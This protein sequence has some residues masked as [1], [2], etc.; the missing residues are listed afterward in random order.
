MK[1]VFLL[2]TLVLL[3]SCSDD[4]TSGSSV[5][6]AKFIDSAVEGLEYSSGDLSGTTASG[7]IFTCNSGDI[8]T[9]KINSQTLG[10]ASC[11][12]VV[13]PY[14]IQS[15]DGL[16][17]NA[18][19]NMVFLLQNLDVDGDPT[20]GI[21]IEAAKKAVITGAISLDND[22]D[23][24][25]FAGNAASAGTNQNKITKTAALDHLKAFGLNVGTYS[26]T[27]ELTN[28]P[29][30]NCSE[31]PLSLDFKGDSFS[32]NVD[33]T[34]Y[35]EN[36]TRGKAVFTTSGTTL[37][38]GGAAVTTVSPDDAT[39]AVLGGGIPA[40]Y[41]DPE[42]TSSSVCIGTATYKQHAVRLTNVSISSGTITGEFAY[43]AQCEDNSV[44]SDY[45]ECNGDFT[46]T[47]K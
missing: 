30:D 24:D 1:K 4:S 38:Y 7:G 5:I 45:D 47:K 43:I 31:L 20:N 19:N 27:Y 40:Y 41:K 11:G 8:V 14:S 9:F 12:S 42:E 36:N 35:S 44:I 16:D 46:F 23:I 13:T 26:G 28:N 21:S 33:G 3:G 15:K 32:V 37:S 34:T 18:L 39:A 6:S 29:Q 2:L 17:D 10:T 25:T 22:G